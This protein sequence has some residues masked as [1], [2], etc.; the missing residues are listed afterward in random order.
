MRTR[1]LAPGVGWLNLPHWSEKWPGTAAVTNPHGFRYVTDHP[2]EP[3]LTDDDLFLTSSGWFP[4]SRVT[5]NSDH[6]FQ[7]PGMNKCPAMT[8]RPYPPAALTPAPVTK[9]EVV[10]S[11]S[12][13][14]LEEA[15]DA[16]LADGWVCQGGVTSDSEGFNLQAMVR[17]T[18]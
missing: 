17:T 12:L 13:T 10:V 7:I 3:P 6:H 18:P 8:K 5:Q 1:H 11:Q 14:G 2:D 4:R 15:V 9:Y 16:K